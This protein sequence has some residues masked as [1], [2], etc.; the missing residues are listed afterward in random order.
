MRAR[1]KF[2]VKC[3]QCGDVF[4]NFSQTGKP[5]EFCEYCLSKRQ[6]E[7]QT[8]RRT[9]ANTHNMPKQRTTEVAQGDANVLP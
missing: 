9:N 1:R 4:E 3:K 5:K 2:V 8:L 7:A 6:K